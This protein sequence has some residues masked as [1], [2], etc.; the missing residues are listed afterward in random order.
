MKRTRFEHRR[1]SHLLLQ[2]NEAAQK[3]SALMLT[4]CL[5]LLKKAL[6]DRI[7]TGPALQLRTRFV[8]EAVD[9]S[10]HPRHLMLGGREVEARIVRRH[11][12]GEGRRSWHQ[13]SPEYP[14]SAVPLAPNR[15]TWV[16][17]PHAAQSAGA[18]LR[19][20]AE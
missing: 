20:A 2:G 19:A 11:R 3:R 9:V 10:Q 5:K 18:A 8:V 13:R 1:P 6:L 15:V 4:A 16:A 14:R 17:R 12:S 7:R